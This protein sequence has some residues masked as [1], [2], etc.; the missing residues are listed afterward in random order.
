MQT[1]GVKVKGFTYYKAN[2]GA[3]L[4]RGVKLVVLDN[5]QAIV[6]DQLLEV[7]NLT[8]KEQ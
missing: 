5:E 2:D 3:V 4:Q 8:A 7:L 6:V 1:K